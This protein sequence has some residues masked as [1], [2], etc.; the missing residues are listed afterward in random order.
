M[1][2]K[3]SSGLHVSCQGE[4]VRQQSRGVGVAEVTHIL[5]EAGQ[6]LLHL[7]ILQEIM[8]DDL[9]TRS[10]RTSASGGKKVRT[11]VLTWLLPTATNKCSRFQI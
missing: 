3:L 4:D 1:L 2:K 5:S 8:T 7:R 9:R 11:P 6:A 10:R